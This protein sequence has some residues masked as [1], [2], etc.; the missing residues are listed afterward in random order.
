[1]RYMVFD[2]IV[3]WPS[4]CDYPLFRKMIRANRHRFNEVIVAFMD[5]N[6]GNDYRQFVRDAMFADH[7]LFVDTHAQAGEDWR[8]VAVNAALIHSYNSPYVWFTEQDF[9]PN[10]YFWA[11]IDQISKCD[12]A[13][14]YQG[15]RLHPCS[16]FLRRDIL[17]QTSKNFAANSPLYDHFGAIARDLV[18]LAANVVTIPDDTYFHYNGLSQNMYL[19]SQGQAPNYE[20]DRFYAYLWLCLKSGVEMPPEFKK[21]VIEAL[22]RFKPIIVNNAIIK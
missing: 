21:T 7:V 14:V 2:V 9:I 17:N 13:G 15:D 20:P 19:V 1:M 8:N 18:T 10:D 12:A 3:T 16:L 6:A 5:A 4:N 22:Q 11:F